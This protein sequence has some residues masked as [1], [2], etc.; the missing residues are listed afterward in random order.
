M[1]KINCAGGP[2]FD[3]PLATVEDTDVLLG[4]VVENEISIFGTEHNR[5]QNLIRS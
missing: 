1:Y 4:I 5:I 3:E 2:L